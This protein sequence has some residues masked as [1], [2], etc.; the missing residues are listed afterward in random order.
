MTDAVLK[1]TIQEWVVRTPAELIAADG[2]GM[3]LF[4]IPGARES[5][6]P[7]NGRMSSDH[8]LLETLAIIL[9]KIFGLQVAPESI[10]DINTFVHLVAVKWEEM[11][12]QS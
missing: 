10:Q 1:R 2:N 7:D 3:R 4:S 11:A 12:E 8:I 9:A 5:A 6:H